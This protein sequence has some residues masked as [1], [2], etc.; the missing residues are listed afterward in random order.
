MHFN[1]YKWARWLLGGA[2]E[3]LR[4]VGRLVCAFEYSSNLLEQSRLR[5]VVFYFF[6]LDRLVK[7]VIQSVPEVEFWLVRG[8]VEVCAFVDVAVRRGAVSLAYPDLTCIDLS[9]I[10]GSTLAP[11]DLFPNYFVV[12]RLWNELFRSAWKVVVVGLKPIFINV[13]VLNVVLLR[14]GIFRA[15][16]PF[17]FVQFG[18]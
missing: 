12:A 2:V 11:C 15:S 1:H 16:Y 10:A 13:L 4:L 8:L 17:T 3:F 9:N 7:F 6:N 5:V 18:F 14:C